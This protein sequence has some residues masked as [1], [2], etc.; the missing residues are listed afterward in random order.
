MTIRLEEALTAAEILP[1]SVGADVRSDKNAGA[2]WVSTEMLKNC[3]FRDK[4]S[5]DAGRFIWVN[6]R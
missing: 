4:V 1:S 3:P 5:N 6:I 2:V